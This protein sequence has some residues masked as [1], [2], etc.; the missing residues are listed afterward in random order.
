MAKDEWP[1]WWEWDIELTPHVFKR[2]LD[3]RFTEVDLRGMLQRAT[4]Y[5]PDACEGR[6]AIDTR[7]EGKPWQ[8]IVEPDD[9]DLL[10]VVITAYPVEIR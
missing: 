5:G 8:V 10:L 7:H 3:R 2:M 1:G 6:F 4:T 9:E